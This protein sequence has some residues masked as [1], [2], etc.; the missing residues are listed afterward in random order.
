MVFLSDRNLS[1]NI[2]INTESNN[3]YNGEETKDTENN[4]NRKKPYFYLYNNDIINK[5]KRKSLINIKPKDPLNFRK[6]DDTPGPGSYNIIHNFTKISIN[7]N[8]NLSFLSNSPRFIDTNNDINLMPDPGIYNL[9]FNSNTPILKRPINSKLFNINSH[10]YSF[11]SL[12]NINSIPVKQQNGYLVDK[13]GQ[14]IQIN[15]SIIENINTEDNIFLSESNK[16]YF[17]NKNPIVKWNRMSARN[18]TPNNNKR[19]LSEELIEDLNKKREIKLSKNDISSKKL[20]L[21][22]NNFINCRRKI[23][24]YHLK[25]L[26][27]NQKNNNFK[28]EDILFKQ[29]EY[30]LFNDKI[31]KIKQ[32][33]LSKNDKDN[34]KDNSNNNINNEKRRKNKKYPIIFR[35]KIKNDLKEMNS[36]K[37]TNPGPGSYFN[38]TY[39]Y[40]FI[41]KNNKN[42]KINNKNKNKLIENQNI[43]KNSKSSFSLLGP[44]SYNIIPK[45]FDKKSFNSFGSFSIEKKFYDY[46]TNNSELKDKHISPGPGQYNLDYKWEKKL[47]QKISIEKLVNAENELKKNINKKLNKLKGDFNNYQSNSI[48]NVIQS[49]IERN[50]NIFSSKRNPFLSGQSR[51]SFS[52]NIENSRNLGPGAYNIKSDFLH[53]NFGK[54]IPFNSNQP[55]E[56]NYLNNEDCSNNVS[57]DNYNSFNWK[58]KSFNVMFI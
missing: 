17:K 8:K 56:L 40:L 43:N 5:N 36:V 58:K 1:S 28:N 34:N 15:D 57:Y 42:K 12:N 26:S 32:K 50:M 11:G 3:I 23:A 13:D 54:N 44:G 37:K 19:K 30:I 53:K 39:K 22:K 38:N 51:F 55:R 4:D 49:K 14:L 25:I 41:K 20:D 16:K 9:S 10:N 31:K 21:N 18:L 27:D 46:S 45:Q 6:E 24:P 33:N 52:K 35:N 7:K 29:K 48:I 2:N 47:K